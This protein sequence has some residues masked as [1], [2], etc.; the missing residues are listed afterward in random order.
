MRLALS[1]CLKHLKLAGSSAEGAEAL[2]AEL[3][4]RRV[5]PGVLLLLQV[6][7][8]PK[9]QKGRP[10]RLP[11]VAPAALLH[12]WARVGHAKKR[13]QIRLRSFQSVSEIEERFPEEVRCPDRS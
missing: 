7:C 9:S 3:L 2:S 1:I 6:S 10:N 12:G 4:H 11:E 13:S 8:E 5:G